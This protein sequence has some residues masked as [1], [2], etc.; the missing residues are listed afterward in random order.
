VGG[1]RVCTLPAAVVRM[2][3][4]VTFTNLFP[5]AMLP[6]HGLFVYERMRRVAAQSKLGW[7]VV[8]PVPQVAW[9][10]RRG[11][12]RRWAAVPSQEPWHGIEIEHPRYRHWPGCSQ[13]RQAD[14]MAAGARQVVSRL[15]E[16]GPIVLDAH[17]LWP[18]GVAAAKLASEFGVPF[19]MTARGSDL[20]V[21]AQDRVV[22]GRIAE[23]AQR[24]FRCCAVSRALGDRFAAVAKLPRERILEVRNGVDLE[25][26]CPGDQAAARQQLG[27]P[28]RGRLLLGVGRLVVGKGFDLAAKALAR[29]P[30]DVS[31]VLVG[32]GPE[33]ATIAESGGERV[34]FLGA[35]PPGEVAVAYRAADLFV[36]PSER[37]GWP[38][39][40]TEALASGLRVVASRVGGIPQI[41]GDAAQEDLSLGALVPSGDV[42][43]LGAALQ[44]VLAVPGDRCRVRA[45]AE[46][47][48]WSEPVAALTQMFEAAFAGSGA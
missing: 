47:Y 34:I 29:L 2:K 3:R 5:S 41:L 33:R 27:L 25:R 14:A 6:T 28:A 44:R 31:L 24:A 36:L 20:N 19:T 18:D 30:E 39:V 8:S 22:A 7:T 13:R 15:V 37:E 42:E 1:A 16:Q 23:A 17:Y 21:V 12:Y 4:I 9:L 48:G 40:V 10:F 35:R 46:R 45:F 32:D 38:N 26:F 11:S 43:A